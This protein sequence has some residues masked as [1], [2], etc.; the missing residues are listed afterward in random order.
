MVA[1]SDTNFVNDIQDALMQDSHVGKSPEDQFYSCTSVQ[2]FVTPLTRAVDEMRGPKTV[3]VMRHGERVD[4]LFPKWIERSQVNDLYEPLDSN[5]P[6]TLDPLT[7][8]LNEYLEDTPLTQMGNVLAQLVGRGLYINGRRPDSIYCSPAL[9][10]VKTA[11][12]VANSAKASCKLNIEAGLFENNNLYPH[13]HPKWVSRN[14]FLNAGF[15]V[16]MEY[17]SFYTQEQIWSRDEIASSYNQRMYATLDHI[18]KREST[19][20]PNGTVLIAAHAST[21]D[22]VSGFLSVP[23]RQLFDKDL[24]N[25]GDRVPYCCTAVFRQVDSF[26]DLK[27]EKKRTNPMRK[28][29][30]V[31]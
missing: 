23:R 21:V 8:P 1:E 18:F 20:N 2:N 19:L 29:F 13:L 12:I 25:V 10:C 16:D 24:F 7:R 6:V 28:H 11:A 3:I 17:K 4:D 22:V 31:N 26:W 9:R 5:M 15:N 27:I 14:E 30:S